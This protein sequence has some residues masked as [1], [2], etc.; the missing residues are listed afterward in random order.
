MKSTTYNKILDLNNN[1]Y[2]NISY[3]FSKTRQR[4]WSGWQLSTT[5]IKRPK[6]PIKILDIGCGNGRYYKFLAKMLPKKSEYI[7]LD[8][9]ELLLNEAKLQIQN[10]S[11]EHKVTFKYFDVI[12]NIHNLRKKYNLVVA[13]GITHHIPSMGG[14]TKWFNTIVK[15]IQPNG[16]LIY[17]IWDFLNTTPNNKLKEEITTKQGFN[18]NKEELEDGDYFLSWDNKPNLYRYCHAYSD[19]EHNQIIQNLQKAGLTMIY[20]FVADGKKNNT[21]KYFIYKKSSY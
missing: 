21:N 17:T 14:R 16:F 6:T 1:F 4:S 2:S 10:V 3:D 5:L 15:L 11:L 8:T 19:A 7:G 20:T 9:N 13:F 12:T 18:F